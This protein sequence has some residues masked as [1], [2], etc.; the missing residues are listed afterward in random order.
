MRKIAGNEGIDLVTKVNTQWQT[1]V[2]LCCT[3][4]YFIQLC[5]FILGLCQEEGCS[6]GVIFKPAL[7]ACWFVS[8]DFLDVSTK[9]KVPALM[10]S[11]ISVHFCSIC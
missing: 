10:L 7:E 11:D 3:V 2:E 4:H 6:G 5:M 9:Q 8:S 1:S